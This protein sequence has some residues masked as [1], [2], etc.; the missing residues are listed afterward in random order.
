LVTS[1]FLRSTTKISSSTPSFCNAHN[2]TGIQDSGRPS[3]WPG[4]HAILASK[5]GEIH[6]RFEIV[7][8][9]EG[10]LTLGAMLSW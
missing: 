5:R 7:R 8:G 4:L 3:I 2:R 1:P 10:R 9:E 6:G